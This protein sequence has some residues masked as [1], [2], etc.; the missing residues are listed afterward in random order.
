MVEAIPLMYSL[1]VVAEVPVALVKVKACRVLDEVARSDGR[2]N[3]VP[4]KVRPEFE[5]KV[6]ASL[7]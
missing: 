1:V 7:Q 4:S 5:V 2:V 3:V 6:L